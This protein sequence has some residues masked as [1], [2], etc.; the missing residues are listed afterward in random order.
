MKFSYLI[1]RTP[2]NLFNTNF[3]AQRSSFQRYCGLYA[4]FIVHRYCTIAHT[5]YITRF[6]S[7]FSYIYVGWNLYPRINVVRSIRLIRRL[8]SNY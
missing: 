5:K 8:K 6:Y 3:F 1:Y 4:F 2:H 7:S